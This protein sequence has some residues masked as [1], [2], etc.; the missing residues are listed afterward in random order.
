VP[1]FGNFTYSEDSSVCLAAIHYGIIGNKGGEFKILI[2][3]DQ[4][5][6]VGSSANGVMS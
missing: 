4:Q 2:L 1:V 6:F 3:G 5:K